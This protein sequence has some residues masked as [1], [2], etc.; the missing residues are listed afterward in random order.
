MSILELAKNV[1]MN[2][3]LSSALPSISKFTDTGSGITTTVIVFVIIFVIVEIL[4]LISLYKLTNS[5]LQVFLGF[6]F[7]I[8]YL[9]IAIIYWGFSGYKLVKI[10]K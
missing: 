9:M 3:A 2:G 8:F 5:G 6:L 1:V 10:N 4:Y 7:G